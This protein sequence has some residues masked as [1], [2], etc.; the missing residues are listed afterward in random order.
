[1]HNISDRIISHLQ[2]ENFTQTGYRYVRILFET[3]VNYL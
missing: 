2:K 3:I 1:M